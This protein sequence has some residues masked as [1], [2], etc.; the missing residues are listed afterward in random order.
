VYRL[1]LVGHSRF[2]DVQTVVPT[3]VGSLVFGFEIGFAYLKLSGQ[4][5]MIIGFTTVQIAPHQDHFWILAGNSIPPGSAC[6][7]DHHIMEMS[8]SIAEDHFGVQSAYG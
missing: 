8:S 6:F 5:S 2:D 3:R 4:V 1:V 7:A